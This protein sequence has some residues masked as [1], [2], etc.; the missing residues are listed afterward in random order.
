MKAV[1]VLLPVKYPAPWLNETLQGLVAQDFSDWTLMVVIHGDDVGLSETVRASGV[2]A[3][4]LR[5]DAQLSL[6]EVLNEGLQ[7]CTAP[8]IARLDADDVP[9]PNRL[10][11]QQSHLERN[12]DSALA[13]SPAFV[14]DGQGQMQGI[15]AV[16]LTPDEVIHSLAWK[17]CIIHPAT[18]FRRESVIGIGGYSSTA[19][20]VEDYELWMRL[21]T[22][23]NVCIAP[24]PAIQYRLHHGQ[25]TSTNVIDKHARA[26][27]RKARLNFAR[28]RGIPTPLAHLQ[29]AI[30]SSRQV[31]RQVVQNLT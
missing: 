15:R 3:R 23:Y 22:P 25:V 10:R 4:V 5:V 8:Y 24:D 31:T 28:A 11:H 9:L 14:I 20:H 21:L 19:R 26:S 1:D 16:P 2:P 17:N 7:I 12:P 30:W 13:V 27:I 29:H 18:M 6:A